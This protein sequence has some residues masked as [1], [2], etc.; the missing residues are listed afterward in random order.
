MQNRFKISYTLL[1]N[2]SGSLINI[3]KKTVELPR[4]VYI[5]LIYKV[6]FVLAFHI[7]RHNYKR[8]TSD[9]SKS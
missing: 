9:V 1:K 3:R 2:Q 4:S 7:Y 8:L 6:F 5:N